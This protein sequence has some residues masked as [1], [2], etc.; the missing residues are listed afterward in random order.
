MSFVILQINL[1]VS[2]EALKEKNH[3]TNVSYY[4]LPRSSMGAKTPLRLSNSVGLKD[5]GYRGNV[6]A[7]VDNNSDESFHLFY[8]I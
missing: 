8:S 7:I 4:L 6:I 3:E 1:K 5:A 2:C